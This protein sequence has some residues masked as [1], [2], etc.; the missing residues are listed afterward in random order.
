MTKQ[1]ETL[2]FKYRML[3]MLLSSASFP[4]VKN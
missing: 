1:R 2:K 4:Y 3:S